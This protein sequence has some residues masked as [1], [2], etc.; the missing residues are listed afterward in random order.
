MKIDFIIQ[1]DGHS[2][3]VTDA[4]PEVYRI[5]MLYDDDSEVVFYS[6]FYDEDAAERYCVRKLGETNNVVDCYYNYC[7]TVIFEGGNEDEE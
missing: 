2:V 7:F 3:V 4:T 1:I 6:S 5:T